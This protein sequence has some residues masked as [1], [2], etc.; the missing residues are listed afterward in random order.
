MELFFI[1]GSG[2]LFYVIIVVCSLPELTCG[3]DRKQ[4]MI[5]SG[6]VGVSGEPKRLEGGR[7]VHQLA[8]MLLCMMI[9]CIGGASGILSESIG[10]LVLKLIWRW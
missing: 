7:I 6:E 1:G 8:G 10:M 9:S 4:V 2:M 3:K 5:R